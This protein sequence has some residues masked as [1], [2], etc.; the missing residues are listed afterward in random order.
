MA[1]TRVGQHMEAAAP[2]S[3]CSDGQSVAWMKAQRCWERGGDER[4][5]VRAGRVRV[6]RG[7]LFRE[8]CAAR[9]A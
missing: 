4:V 9:A 2:V 7:L 1:K 3:A 8:G 5:R 6:K